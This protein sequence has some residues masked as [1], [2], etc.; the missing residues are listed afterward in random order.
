MCQDNKETTEC[1]ADSAALLWAGWSES[2]SENED[3][4]NEVD[5]PMYVL[6]EER[7]EEFYTAERTA[8]PTHE[9]QISAGLGSRDTP[10]LWALE[11]SG[12]MLALPQQLAGFS[13]EEHQESK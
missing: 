10:S 13:Q 11:D 1:G 2:E 6:D 3:S 5:D 7:E 12:G 9:V 4:D 8:W